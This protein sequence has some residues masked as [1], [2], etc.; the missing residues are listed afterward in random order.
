MKKSLWGLESMD[1]SQT[2]GN[3]KYDY[4]NHMEIHLYDEKKTNS[5]M[6]T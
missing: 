6:P 3:Q 1:V 2:S 5:C 4:L